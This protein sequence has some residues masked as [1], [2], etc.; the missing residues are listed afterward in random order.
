MN[1]TTLS[2]ALV[3]ALLGLA[4]LP[5]AE[6]SSSGVNPV[7][8]KWS[9]NG[10]YYEAVLVPGGITWEQ[11][12]VAAFARGG[13]LATLTS[14]AE[15]D[16]AH[17]LIARSSRYWAA[18]GNAS[19]PS[20]VG[21]WI[22]LSQTNG[23]PEPAGGWTWVTGQPLDYANWAP[24][25]PNNLENKENYAHFWGA[26]ADNRAKTWNDIP[27]DPRDLVTVASVRPV[28][29]VVEYDAN[30]RP[31]PRRWSGNGHYYE[32]ISAPTGLTWDDAR[33]AARL[34]G[35]YLATL[36]SAEE[37][38]FVHSLIAG[39]PG[40]WNTLGTAPSQ[41]SGG[42]WI[43]LYQTNGAPEPAG[44]WTWI[45]G[46]PYQ[47]SNW[48]TNRPN[49]LDGIENYGQFW[50]LGLTNYAPT[51]NDLPNDPLQLQAVI[52]P[53]PVAY[54]VEY[55]R[56]PY[57]ARRV[58][59]FAFV[60]EGAAAGPGD[61]RLVTI[62]KVQLGT[63]R[64]TSTVQLQGE[65][66]LFETMFEL[67]YVSG[68]G[69]FT[70]FLSLVWTNGDVVACRY[71]ATVRRAAD[72]T[73]S[74]RSELKVIDGSGRFAGAHGQGRLL[75]SRSGAPGSPVRYEVEL[76]VRKDLSPS[77]RHGHHD[78]SEHGER[79]HE[80]SSQ[81]DDRKS[82]S[83]KDGSDDDDDDDRHSHGN[84][85]GSTSVHGHGPGLRLD[86]VLDALP[87]DQRLRAI[88]VG[89]RIV[90]GLVHASGAAEGAAAPVAV[91]WLGTVN[92]RD[93]SGPVAGY[94][95]LDFGNGNVAYARYSGRAQALRNGVV[96]TLAGLKV[97]AGTGTYAGARGQGDFT[98]VHL[99][100]GTSPEAGT[101][102][103]RWR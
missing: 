70:G 89:E 92:V 102:R 97:L 30:P 78:Q 67:H 87:Q 53:R 46:E 100:P 26:G 95:R 35:G 4:T 98:G 69:P 45:T 60:T 9:G 76:V 82:Y 41:T 11:A 34:R 33:V 65:P 42:P 19:S 56:H 6:A 90:Y 5:V 12:R 50:G 61:A 74:W 27:N 57:A 21:P 91:E 59:R 37:N 16:F 10:H 83:H 15:N 72:G 71:N 73:S 39:T 54:V 31:Y 55:D 43:G 66:V 40:Y 3:A 14:A 44:G 49:N 81:D 52:A 62:D 101:V 38:A 88:G 86:V 75:G 47:Y 23:S 25:R 96:R 51:W 20:T 84:G 93:D 79:E 85:G 94:L 80:G 18:S 68:N 48:G 13:Y 24:G 7:P 8:R 22:G 99:A 28:A 77:R 103:L 36:T 1:A 58:E 17:S 2:R 64:L 32:V 63:G 29:Y